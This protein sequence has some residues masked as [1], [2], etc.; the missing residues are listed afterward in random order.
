[1]RYMPNKDEEEEADIERLMTDGPP[2]VEERLIRERNRVV[3]RVITYAHVYLLNRAGVFL[4]TRILNPRT[5][6]SHWS[7]K[8]P[9][10]NP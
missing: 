7:W 5:R 4:H 10:G 2:T 3:P 1:M 9:G 6:T 8:P